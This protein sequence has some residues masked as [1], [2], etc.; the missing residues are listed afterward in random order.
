MKDTLRSLAFV[1]FLQLPLF[2][3]TPCLPGL[4]GTHAGDAPPGC[5]MCGPIYQGHMNGFTPDSVSFDF[6]CGTIENSQWLS[7][8][9]D[10][11]GTIAVTILSSDCLH[12]F[13][14]Q[15]AI[16]DKNLNRVSDCVSNRTANLPENLMVTDLDPLESYLLMIDGNAGDECEIL[17]LSTTVPSSFLM[18]AI[19]CPGDCFVYEDTCYYESQQLNYFRP[20]SLDFKIDLAVADTGYFEIRHLRDTFINSVAFDWKVLGADSFEIWIDDVFRNKQAHSSYLLPLSPAIPDSFY[21]KVI[22]SNDLGCNFRTAEILYPGE[23]I[24]SDTELFS[25]APKAFVAPNPSENI[26]NVSSTAKILKISVYDLKGKKIT[27]SHTGE[28]D[29]SGQKT[30]VYILKIFTEAGVL[31]RKII[32]I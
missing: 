14:I 24:S 20:C 2:A 18:E 11:H 9:P 12:G 31:I 4:D 28:L 15:F 16:Y 26:F 27:E 21:F 5:T 22:P 1:L 3:Q 6:P 25:R 29:M 17:V 30:G 32:K 19:I 10:R 23:G 8:F 13:G 7:L